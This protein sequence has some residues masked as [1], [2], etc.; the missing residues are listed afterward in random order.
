MSG[1]DLSLTD[2]AYEQVDILRG[3]NGRW[4]LQ[5]DGPIAY[6]AYQHI[7]RGILPAGHCYHA[8]ESLRPGQLENIGSGCTHDPMGLLC[9]LIHHTDEGH[10][11]AFLC[12]QLDA[13]GIAIVTRQIRWQYAV[14]FVW[15][16]RLRGW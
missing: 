12:E 4:G 5:R 2:F 6:N 9:D 11:N 3:K 14:V 8:D 10:R 1:L 16:G 7:L 13:Q 15:R